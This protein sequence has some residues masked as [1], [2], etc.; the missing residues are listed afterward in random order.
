MPWSDGYGVMEP[1]DPMPVKR[2][3]EPTKFL[4]VA[5]M[6]GTITFLYGMYVFEH[7]VPRLQIGVAE[8]H[9]DG[10]IRARGQMELI[11]FHAITALLLICY[12]RAILTVP[13]YIP[14]G[15]KHWEYQSE[16]SSSFI[17]S[18][19][20]EMK[21]TGDRRHCKWCSKFKP[22]RTHHCRVCKTCVLK[23]DHH[24][25]WIYNC[26]GFFNYKYFFLMLF[27]SMLDCH[28]IAWTMAETVQ[29]TMEIETPFI[30]MFLILF[31][32]TLAGFLGL[33]VTLF[34]MFHIWLM[35]SAMTTIEFCEKTLPKKSNSPAKN[36]GDGSLYDMG[37]YANIAAVLGDNVLLWLL[38]LNGPS[39]D[40]L[41][42]GTSQPEETLALS[43]YDELDVTKRMPRGKSDDRKRYEL[44]CDDYDVRMA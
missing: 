18:F 32:E 22:D 34:F 27:Y 13:G 14:A 6:C 11:T 30:T 24:C 42:Y 31:A 26:V 21:K 5:F 39:G 35:L 29:K 4:P 9:V 43:N 25:P 15:D 19:L 44:G 36:L 38:P 8:E 7:C 10:V 20:R 3:T 23:M 37:G 12:L 33:L 16:E 2:F 1:V 28:L 40:G 17:P 41:K